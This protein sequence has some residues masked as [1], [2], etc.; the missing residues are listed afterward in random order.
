MF[1]KREICYIVRKAP[2][3]GSFKNTHPREPP[4]SLEVSD[5]NIAQLYQRVSSLVEESFCD[6]EIGNN[7][8]SI[9]LCAAGCRNVEINLGSQVSWLSEAKSTC[10]SVPYLGKLYAFKAKV[11]YLT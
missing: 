9:C 11:K 5:P 2:T 7:L 6:T 8:L 1:F 3:T 10:Q 4:C